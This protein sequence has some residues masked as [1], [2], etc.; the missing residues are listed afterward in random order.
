MSALDGTVESPNFDTT[1]AAIKPIQNQ[2]TSWD[3]IYPVHV[4]QY[5]E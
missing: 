1:A 3:Y 2:N 5:E 4:N